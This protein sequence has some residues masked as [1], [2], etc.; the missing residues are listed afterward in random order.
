MCSVVSLLHQMGGD[1]MLERPTYE[2][3]KIRLARAIA[4]DDQHFGTVFR[5][6]DKYS[7]LPL[8][9]FMAE[10]LDLRREKVEAYYHDKALP[11]HVLKQVLFKWL[12]AKVESVHDMRNAP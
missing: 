3:V 2:E 12:L 7:S 8:V 10:E 5:H 1:K 4:F 11:P 9:V 6:A